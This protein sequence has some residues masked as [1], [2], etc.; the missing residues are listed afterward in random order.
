MLI[1][2]SVEYI[3]SIFMLAACLFL[4]AAWLTFGTEN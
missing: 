4:G 2:V 1:D 3:V